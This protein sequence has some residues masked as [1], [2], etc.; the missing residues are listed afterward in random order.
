MVTISI[1]SLSIAEWD[2]FYG[3]CVV[4]I[5][6]SI[7]A[8]SLRKVRV[9]WSWSEQAKTVVRQSQRA[10]VFAIVLQACVLLAQVAL[11]LP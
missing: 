11:M 4:L 1:L 7:A 9:H 8:L 5:V 10:A 6:S 3:G 2:V